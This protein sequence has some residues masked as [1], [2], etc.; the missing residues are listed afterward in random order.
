MTT[1]I[2]LATSFSDIFKSSFLENTTSFSL[3]DS[4]IAL[5]LALAIG[6]FIFFIYKKTFTG[7][8]YSASFGVSLLAMT[9]ITTFILLAV[10]SNVVLSL[11][12]PVDISWLW[13]LLG[14]S[15][16]AG[17]A[18]VLVLV[19]ARRRRKNIL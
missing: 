6:L 4:A 1:A 17:T 12:M 16:A 13:K 11:G 19:I 15:A 2:S 10:T 8:M 5:A 18:L 9:L 14:Y 7:V 3:V